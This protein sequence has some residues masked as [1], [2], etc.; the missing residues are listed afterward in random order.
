M[1]TKVTLQLQNSQIWA[2][3]ET[4]ESFT[5]EVVNPPPPPFFQD[6]YTSAGRN[7]C[8]QKYYQ[9]SAQYQLPICLSDYTHLKAIK[10][11]WNCQHVSNMSQI[12]KTD[13]LF[14]FLLLL[15]KYRQM[16]AEPILQLLINDSLYLP[17]QS[18]AAL[19]KMPIIGLLQCNKILFCFPIHLRNSKRIMHIFYFC[20]IYSMNHGNRETEE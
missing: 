11:L 15:F 9:Y 16:A 14:C 19:K 2:S 13:M 3:P 8:I 4:P 18:K 17:L 1:K 10:L 20:S 12:E 7:L 5:V 6:L